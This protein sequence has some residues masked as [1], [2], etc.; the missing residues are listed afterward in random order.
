[1]KGWKTTAVITWAGIIA[2]FAL[3]SLFMGGCPKP[4]P[5][6]KPPVPIGLQPCPIDVQP[7]TENGCDGVFTDHGL[8]CVD[9]GPV[10]PCYDEHDAIYCVGAGG[11]LLDPACKGLPPP[12]G[13]RRA[14]P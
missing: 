11:C 6:P 9:C 3:L 7:L 14:Q 10:G 5:V 1:M 4:V 8:L 2:F 12:Q 13:R